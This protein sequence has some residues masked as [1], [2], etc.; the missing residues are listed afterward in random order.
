MKSINA[1]WAVIRLLEE[2]LN[3][4]NEVELKH[5]LKRLKDFAQVIECAINTKDSDYDVYEATNILCKYLG[6]LW[7][8]VFH[9]D[10]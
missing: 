1:E 7:R 4:R 2:E 9:I 3:S 10:N 5:R 8:D 6:V